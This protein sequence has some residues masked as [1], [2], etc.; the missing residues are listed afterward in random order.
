MRGSA[1]QV[2][3]SASVFADEPAE[4]WSDPNSSMAE[5]QPFIPTMTDRRV[6][7]GL[8]GGHESWLSPASG[9]AF[10]W[11]QFATNSRFRPQNA[12]IA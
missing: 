5:S 11:P 6:A 2:C 7:C 8:N 9:D 1:L 10:F 4:L 12:Q 3:H